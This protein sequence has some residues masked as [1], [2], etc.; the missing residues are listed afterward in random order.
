MS[1]SSLIK[2]QALRTATL[3]KR[4]SNTGN[5]LRILWIVQ[6][7]L[8]CVEDVWTAGSET[9]VRLFKNTFFNRTFPVAASDSFRFPAC[10]F[11]KK[12]T[13]AKMFICEFCKIFKNIFRQKHLRMT[14][15]CVYLWILRSFSDHLFYRAPLGNCLFHLQ[16][17]EFKTPHTVKKYF[18]SAVQA[19]Y[20]GRGSSCS[21][22]F[23][24]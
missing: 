10:N 8:F 22:A 23:M 18:A 19:F 2:L 24:Y 21:N 9:P 7:H 11:I 20:T 15:S 6:K 5:L 4:D 13:P 16:V 12:E 3:L 1:E 14:A 17:A